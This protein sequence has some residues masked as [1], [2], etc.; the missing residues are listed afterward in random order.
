MQTCGLGVEVLIEFA[1]KRIVNDDGPAVGKSLD[2]MERITRHDRDQAR[3]RDLSYTLDDYLELALDHFV[4][5]FL[6]MEVLVN[7][8]ATFEV[9][10]RERHARRVEVTSIP[11]GQAFDGFEAVRVDER[12]RFSLEIS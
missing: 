10:M 4:N 6:R 3:A 12:H 1:A 7:S 11:A 2:R 8:C 5:F 9:I